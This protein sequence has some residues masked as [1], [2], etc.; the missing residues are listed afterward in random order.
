VRN[1]PGSCI[2]SSLVGDYYLIDLNS[3]CGV[4]LVTDSFLRDTMTFSAQFNWVNLLSGYRRIQSFFLRFRS[5]RT[6]GF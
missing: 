1:D 3:Y 5:V 4:N 2:S 6:S